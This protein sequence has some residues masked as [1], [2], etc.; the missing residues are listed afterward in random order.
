MIWLALMSIFGWS[1]ASAPAPADIPASLV[2]TV[3][4]PPGIS[5]AIVSGALNEAADIW[6]AAG[7]ALKW[8]ASNRPSMAI[9]PSAV[10]VLLDD[11]QAPPSDGSLALGWVAFGPS[12]LPAP[13]LHLSH[14][15]AIRL[16]EAETAYRDRPPRYK[17]LL[18]A[19]A[20]G[21]VLA[22][23]LGHYLMASKDHSP[24]GLMKAHRL[25]DELFSPTRS[26]FRLDDGE[27]RLAGQ[28]PVLAQGISCG[29]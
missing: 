25:A 23:E 3:A 8:R 18:L 15:N 29:C 4:A 6:R 9:E 11:E 19:R 14:R 22:H 2:L 26:G 27:R 21:R 24:S 1:P 17:E 7:L 28:A 16:L 12:G 13:L 10:Q 20:L 5:K